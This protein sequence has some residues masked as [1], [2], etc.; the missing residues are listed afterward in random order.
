MSEFRFKHFTVDMK[1]AAMK[2]GT[3]GVLVGAWASFDNARR[4]LDIGCGTG[5]ISLMAAQRNM[6][7][8]ITAIDIDESAVECSR[9]NFERSPWADRLTAECVRIQDYTASEQ[10]DSIISNPPYFLD[11]LLSPS[12]KRTTARHAVTLT[13]EELNEG[14]CRLLS[15]EGTFTLILPA[16]EMAVFESITTLTMQRRCDVRSVEEGPVKRVM[17][18]FGYRSVEAPIV[19][20]LTIELPARGQFTAEYRNLT[21]DFYLKF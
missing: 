3:D 11:S 21:K 7:A 8:A 5:V 6:S 2:V 15:R 12:Q 18:E 16:E 17:A 4:I 14:V 1:G 9:R 19:E 13:Y 20:Q 10:F